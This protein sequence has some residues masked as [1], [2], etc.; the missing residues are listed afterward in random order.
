MRYET[1]L[2][3]TNLQAFLHTLAYSEGTNLYPLA[4]QYRVKFGSTPKKPRLCTSMLDHP[5]EIYQDKAFPKGSD[6]SGRYQFMSFTW[7]VLRKSLDLPD[8]SPKCQDVACT[9]LISMCNALNDICL[10]RFD[11]AVQKCNRTWASLP[12]SPYGQPT[13]LLVALR[14]YYIT[15]GGQISMIE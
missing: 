3:N 1:T 11:V 13:H 6:A 14:N 2:K 7:D 10:G 15:M 12:G 8:F 5:R 9:G 4:D